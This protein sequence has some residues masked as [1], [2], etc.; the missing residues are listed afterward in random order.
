MKKITF[1]F[2][3]MAISVGLSAQL[4]NEDFE[5]YTVGNGIAE[6]AGA[7][8]TTWSNAPGT[9]ED[10]VI[11]DVMANSG[12]QSVYVASGND[13]VLE[14][15]DQTVGRYRIDFDINIEPEKFGYFNVLQDFDGGN[16]LWGTQFYFRAGGTGSVDAGGGDAATFD[17]TPG[18]WI[19]IRIFIDIDNDFATIV[20]D[21]TELVSWTW[22]TGA[23]GGNDLNQLGA[24]NFYAWEEEGTAGYYFDDV[25]VTELP[26][27]DPP[28]NL[29]ATLAEDDI[30]LTWDEPVSGAPDSYILVRNGQELAS[31]LDVTSYDDL[32][33][34]PGPYTYIVMAYDPD[35]G[36][37]SASNEASE[38]V[39]GGVARDLVL[40]EIGTGTWCTYCPGSA[41]GADDMVENGHDVAIL[42]YHYGDGYEN[43]T[44]LARID[45]YGIASYPTSV[46]DGI[47]VFSGG[48]ATETLYPSYLNYYNSRI[49]VPS[50]YTLGMDITHVADETFNVN[51]D[52]TE[53]YEYL[54][55]DVTLH[56]AITE[57]H[58][59]D[60]WLVMDEVNFFCFDMLP[61]A[62]G[63][64]L[65]FS[66]GTT[67]N[68]NQDF[69]LDMSIHDINNCE[70]VAFVQD[71]DSKEIINAVKLD[72]EVLGLDVNS[73]TNSNINIYPNPV[74]DRL[75]VETV[76][77]SEIEIFDISGKVVY[78]DELKQNKEVINFT[79]F[80]QGVYFVKVTTNNETV[81]QKVVLVK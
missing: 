72:L 66:S 9:S 15:G 67:D 35:Q 28:Q 2:F 40:Y 29:T 65:D 21:G 71:E 77:V 32:N 61:D 24:M 63:T 57:S 43:P 68:L 76:G 75:T 19:H 69:T 51:I 44:S 80:N 31:G 74:K 16:S 53:E 36:Y 5:A 49:S 27:F 60:S 54:T 25:I 22:S 4:V 46:I 6:D 12:T 52:V 14:L 34:Y 11:S 50:L 58:I 26:A 39:A 48:S 73:L 62:T 13:G 20:L 10:P 23:F 1:I 37:S 3:L 81:T 30:S 33:L 18:E 45:Y 70:V 7:P 59:P 78:S 8:W 17:Y 56:V 79:S 42:E 64:L 55:G 38:T 41:M 47:N